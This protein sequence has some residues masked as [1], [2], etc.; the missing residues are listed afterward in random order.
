MKTEIDFATIVPKFDKLLERG[1]C[2]G[3]GN[4]DGQMCI[5]A[6]IACAM[7]LPFNDEP[8]CVEPAVRAFKIALNDSSRW[9]SPEVRAKALRNIGIAQ[10]GSAV[11]VDGNE[12][13]KRLAEKTIRI[14]IPHIFNFVFKDNPACLAAAERCRL[15]GTKDAAYAA[16]NADEI[17]TMSANI[18][19]EIL[20]ELK[21]PGCEWLAKESR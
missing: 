13:A 5:E 9:S 18:A 11:V 8:T 1:L 21:S 7:D 12:F 3:V 2:I 6:A 19:L 15:E 4:P 14:I 10:I 16:A 20:Q 17:L